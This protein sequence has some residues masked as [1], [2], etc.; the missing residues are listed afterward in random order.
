MTWFEYGLH[1]LGPE[2]YTAAAIYP[3]EDAPALLRAWRDFA[4]Q[5]PDEVTS[6][7]LFWSMPPLPDLP[8]ELHGAPIFV[9]AGMYAGPADEGE[10]ALEPLRTCGTPI[11]D[12][13]GAVTYVESQSAF[14]EFFPDT[15][16]YY[17]KSLYLDGLD[18]DLIDAIGRHGRHAPVAP[19]AVRPAPSGRRDRPD[20]RGRDRLRPP[21]GRLQPEPR[22]DLGRRRRTTSA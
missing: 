16:R 21:P 18:D 20:P 3:F 5:A 10:R 15:L 7:A 11:V 19:D 12:L 22:R 4:E 13:S 9:L 8:A 17:W 14:D 1:P 6:Q 2:V